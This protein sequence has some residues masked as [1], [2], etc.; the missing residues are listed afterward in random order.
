MRKW[1]YLIL[2]Q[3]W[4]IEYNEWRYNL[5]E[6]NS[7]KEDEVLN[8]LGSLGWELFQVRQSPQLELGLMYFYFKRPAA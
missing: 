7:R 1:E 2:L 8:S 4:S 6:Y 5:H 3:S